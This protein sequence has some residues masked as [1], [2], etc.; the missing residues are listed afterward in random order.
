MP[1][2]IPTVIGAGAR[3]E[4]LLSFRGAARVEGTLTG[5]IRA[6]GRLEVGP[7]AHIRARVEVDELVLEGVLEGDVDAHERAELL[8]TAR[9]VGNL[10]TPRIRLEEG[11]LLDG[12]C[13]MPAAGRRLAGE[14]AARAPEPVQ[15]RDSAAESV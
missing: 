2:P 6:S 4:G 13:Q 10:V 3:F 12:E 15:A 8:P 11:S 14:P 7:H 9:L 5:T 1:N